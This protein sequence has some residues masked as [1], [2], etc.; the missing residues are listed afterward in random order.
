M[1]SSS[2]SGGI[3][4]G[5]KLLVFGVAVLLWMLMAGRIDQQELT[6]GALV[7]LALVLLFPSRL[8]VFDGVILSW[9]TPLHIVIY[10]LYFTV[11]LVRANVDLAWRVLSPS[12]P[13][14]P[15]LVRIKTPLQSRLGRM[16]LANTITLTPGTLTVDIEG[17]ELLIH[18][19]YCP[20]G[21][22]PAEIS[23]R[24][25]GDFGRLLGKFLK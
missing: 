1:D 25:A 4:A 9:A 5:H 17:D 2:A 15:E 19:V 21:L 18:W 14:R 8:G 10:L 13:I 11:A 6:A 3:G 20:A 7:A 16:L 24:V 22:E 12:L 23:R